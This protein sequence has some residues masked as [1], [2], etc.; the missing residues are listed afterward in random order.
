VGGTVGGGS[1]DVDDVDDEVEGAG[2]G[3]PWGVV[4]PEQDVRRSATAATPTGASYR[5]LPRIM[6]RP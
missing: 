4:S 5:L 1:E 3:W 2:L 6:S